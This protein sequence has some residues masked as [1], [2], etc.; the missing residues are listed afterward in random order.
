MKRLTLQAPNYKYLEQ[1]FKEWL[2][3][4]GY[5][6]TTV[7]S[8]PVHVRE[9]LHYLEQKQVSHITQVRPEHVYAFIRYLKTRK[10]NVHGGALSSSTINKT[11]Q[12]I[13]TFAGY[14]NQTGKHI[15]D[16]FPTRQESRRNELP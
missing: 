8:F 2:D 11:I 6:E 13:N 15:L 3:V 12:S 7:N 1:G 14:L 10:N 4:L 16:L 9:L 5:A